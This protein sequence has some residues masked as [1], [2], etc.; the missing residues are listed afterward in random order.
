M[1]HNICPMG[2]YVRL[3]VSENEIVVPFTTYTF[4]SCKVL[5]ERVNLSLQ[6]NLQYGI[7]RNHGVVSLILVM[8]IIVM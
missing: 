2:I 8:L 4:H 6:S 3:R 1:Q 7:R 5:L